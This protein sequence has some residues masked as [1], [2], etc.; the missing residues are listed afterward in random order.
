M[1]AVETPAYYK[2]VEAVAAVMKKYP[3][4]EDCG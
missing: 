3:R 2:D 1:K 4:S